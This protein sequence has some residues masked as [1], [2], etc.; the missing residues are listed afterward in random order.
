[1]AIKL[2]GVD[3]GGTFTDF[4]YLSGSELKVHKVL[5]SPKAPQQAILQGIR[6]MGL[7]ELVSSGD[8]LI[9]HGTTVATN[10]TLQGNGV[11]T[12]YITN[13]GLKDV[14]IIGRQAREQL[15][16]LTPVPTQKP[17]VDKLMLEVSARTSASGD[18]ISGFYPGELEALKSTVDA[19]APE[20]VA[21]N[22]LFSFLAPELEEELERLFVDDYFVSRSSAVLP[23]HRE[24]ERGITTWL[25]AWIGP[26]IKDY[27]MSLSREVAPAPLS[28]MQSSGLTIDAK[29]AS[30]RA[31]NLLLSGPA[32][33][34]SAAQYIGK[35]VRQEKLITFDMGGTSSDV[36]LIEGRFK[37]TNHGQIGGYPV[38]V[39][40]ADIHTIGAGGGSIAF[41]DAGGLL[42]VGPQSAGAEP[43]PACYNRGGTSATVT[44]ANLVLG[45]L[46][47]NPFL[48]GH[49]PLKGQL[50]REALEP[51]AHQLDVSVEEIAMG[52]VRLANE[53][54]SQ[55]LRVISIQR[56]HDPREFTLAC[57]GGAGG[58]H[59]CD[60]AESLEMRSA[61]VPVHGG[62]LSALG[63]LTTRPGREL[64]RTHQSLLKDVD[65]ASLE[66]RFSII[67]HQA[68][69]ELKKE[70]VRET[71]QICSLDL[72]YLGQTYTINI[73]YKGDLIASENSF[74]TAHK[75]QY[76]HQMDLPIE[77]LNYRVHMEA[78]RDEIS[79]PDWEPSRTESANDDSSNPVKLYQRSCLAVGAKLNGPAVIMEDHATTY[80]KPGWEVT[81]DKFGNLLLKQP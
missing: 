48:A 74:H 29:L 1:M 69:E 52:I 56:G 62:V 12:V 13:R 64:V 38:S 21:I 20:S 63:M 9:V 46:G 27:M 51:L 81:V 68:A 55:A 57:F 16:N 54:M 28:I 43:G 15:Y 44:D 67:L 73:P 45:R 17:F 78:N 53:H 2:L 36:A 18:Q 66:A 49:L 41:V 35:L 40:M 77:L 79:L 39:P 25:N 42:Q 33:G 6:E 72:R 26:I 19:L 24:Y 31:V 71:V 4:V 3:T 70:G 11:R 23:E 10:A 5:S 75:T 32:G 60:L 50:A 65:E 7:T 59:L 80:I 37:L 76:G 61:I 47:P 58:L 34:L 8:V 22:L 14:L 30:T